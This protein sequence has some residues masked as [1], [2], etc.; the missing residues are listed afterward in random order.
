MK[1]VALLLAAAAIGLLPAAPADAAPRAFVSSTGSGAT[2]TRAA[3]CA[4]FQAAHDAT[5]P[6]GEVNCLDGGDYGPINISKSISI[7]CT[8][9]AGTIAVTTGT[10]V[11]ISG[12]NLI[13]RL[14]GLAILAAGA[15]A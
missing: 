7:D 11:N 13:V 5:D 15:D 9:T 2:C 10:G 12:S 6:N 1:A 8:G 4:T 3:P 14:R